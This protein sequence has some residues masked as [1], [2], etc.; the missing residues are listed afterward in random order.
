MNEN[1]GTYVNLENASFWECFQKTSDIVMWLQ[2][3]FS[4][5]HFLE[6]SSFKE[7]LNDQKMQAYSMLF[8]VSRTSEGC[9]SGRMIHTQEKGLSA[10]K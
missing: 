1:Q 4:L 6:N 8:Q 2:A 10:G 5:V 9:N 7:D 3:F